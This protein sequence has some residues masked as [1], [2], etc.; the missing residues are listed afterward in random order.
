MK[1]LAALTAAGALSLAATSSFAQSASTQAASTT[2][3]PQP[4]GPEYTVRTDGG[5]R[6]YVMRDEVHVPGEPQRPYAFAVTG[7]SPLGYTALED[8]R[9]FL[10]AVTA[11]VR[12]D[13]F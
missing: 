10:P 1:I 7:R 12:W 4:T 2:P 8:S 13:P 3:A 9:S 5:R 6:V 11:A